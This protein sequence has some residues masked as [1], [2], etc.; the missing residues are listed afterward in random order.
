MCQFLLIYPE[1]GQHINVEN[2]FNFIGCM[3][4]EGVAR[5][6]TSIVNQDSNVTDLLFDSLGY[7]ENLF[8]IRYVASA[9]RNKGVLLEF[10]RI[11]IIY[12]HFKK[13]LFPSI[14]LH[15]VE[16]KRYILIRVRCSRSCLLYF[17]Q[18][19]LVRF[20]IQIP[21]YHDCAQRCITK[22]QFSSDAMTRACYL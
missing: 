9:Y 5:H 6:Y 15:F 19:L 21:T 7:A 3:I 13:R 1:M 22:C 17:A 8:P 20:L 10:D 4:K 12:T 14:L 16:K 2:S 11:F 18:C